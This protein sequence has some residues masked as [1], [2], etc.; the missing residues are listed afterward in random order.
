MYLFFVLKVKWGWN[1]D[2]GTK[3]HSMLKPKGLVKCYL[4][5]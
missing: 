4:V 3:C 2:R 5:N 1:N